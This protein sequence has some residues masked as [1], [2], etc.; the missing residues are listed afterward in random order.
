[1][2]DPSQPIPVAGGEGTHSVLSFLN[3]AHSIGE[4]FLVSLTMVESIAL[5]LV[6]GE[7]REAVIVF[8]WVDVE[9][10]IMGSLRAMYRD[11]NV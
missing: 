1:M 5:R 10:V 8:P 2:A 11:R 7:F 3:G 9:R 4:G 6:C